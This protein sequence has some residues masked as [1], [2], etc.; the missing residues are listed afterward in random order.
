MS[1]SVI[2][3]IFQK[4]LESIPSS[5]VCINDFGLYRNWHRKLTGIYPQF[6]SFVIYEH[7][8]KAKA[9]PLTL[10]PHRSNP[11]QD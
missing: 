2:I 8:L 6:T 7:V 4:V 1:S 5:L 9:F 11:N 3:S 10:G